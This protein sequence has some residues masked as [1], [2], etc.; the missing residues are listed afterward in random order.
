MVSNHSCILCPGPG[1]DLLPWDTKKSIAKC[2]DACYG[3][4]LLAVTFTCSP[5]SSQPQGQWCHI[6]LW[7]HGPRLAFQVPASYREGG[8]LTWHHR[9]HLGPRRC[10]QSKCRGRSRHRPWMQDVRQHASTSPS[11]RQSSTTRAFSNCRAHTTKSTLYPYFQGVAKST[12]LSS[13]SPRTEE[14]NRPEDRSSFS[15][16]LLV[17]LILSFFVNVGCFNNV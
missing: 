3:D 1:K 15:T 5:S 11:L 17:Y 2:S 10:V 9:P 13:A 7:P 12:L 14:W 6:H 8:R 16:S 4:H